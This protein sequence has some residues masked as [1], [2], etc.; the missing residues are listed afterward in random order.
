MLTVGLFPDA[1]QKFKTAQV[2]EHLRRQIE[3]L[4]E[5]ASL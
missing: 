3:L 1:A 4:K 2:N 5:S